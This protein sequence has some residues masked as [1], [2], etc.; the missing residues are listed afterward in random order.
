MSIKY[1]SPVVLTFILISAAVMICKSMGLG[2]IHSLFVLQPGFNPINPFA[3]FRLFSH[4]LGH[5][6][7]NHLI[8]NTT[9]LVLVGPILEEKY[10]SSS[11]AFMIFMTALVTGILNTMFFSTGLLGA[12]G[13]VFMMIILVSFVNYKENQIPL[14][15][16]IVAFL[17]LGAELKDIFKDDHI[18][19]FAHLLGGLVGA[20]FGFVLP[21][22]KNS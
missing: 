3:Y 6:D 15:F 4:V 13:I 1:N 9:Y 16:I 2:F 17:Y 10:G 19:R 14:T 12:S 7:W 22:K 18:S 21:N 11:M 8:G 5:A 20:A